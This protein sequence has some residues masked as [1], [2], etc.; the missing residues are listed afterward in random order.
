MIE[1]YL[2][3]HLIYL[4]GP[5]TGTTYSGCT[6]WRQEVL[7]KL[8]R[9]LIGI[10]PMR[11]KKYLDGGAEFGDIGDSYPETILS[12]QRG[13]FARD[14][15]D[16]QRCDAILVNLKGAAKVSIGTVMEIAWGVAYNKPIVLLMEPEVNIH[17]HSMIREACPFRVATMEDAIGTLNALF[18][19]A[20]H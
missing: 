7:E 1:Q 6:D 19:P 16:C 20:G 11:Y 17:E 10:S 4:A 15:W 13:I 18:V 8:P 3:Q 14:H 9:G 2:Q 12:C 5:I